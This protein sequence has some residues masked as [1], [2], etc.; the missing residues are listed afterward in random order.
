MRIVAGLYRGR[1]LAAPPGLATR[2]TSDRARQAVFNVLEH[3]AWSPGL[4]GVR[5]IDLFAGSGALGLEALSRG[6]DFCLFVE[7]DAAARGAIR[8]N[9]DTLAPDGGLNGKSRIHR[10][11]AT[12]LGKKP[13]G[14]GAPFDLA[15]L[16]PPYARG[17]GERALAELARGGW[18][19][20]GAICVFERGAGEPDPAVAAFTSLDARR[21]G[22]ARVHVLK[23]SP[24]AT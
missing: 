17:L 16:D 9:L 4:Q 24:G 6:A 23:Y 7:T 22:A 5:I 13:A 2:P 14:D 19:A 3:A 8:D 18:L 20:D 1:A 12:D 21:Y 11:D 15:F 10:R